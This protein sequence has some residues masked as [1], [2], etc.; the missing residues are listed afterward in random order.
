MPF[1]LC[2]TTTTF[3]QCMHSLFEECFDK[4]FEILKDSISIFGNNFGNCL[5]NLNKVLQRC[6][7]SNYVLNWEKCHF[8]ITEEIAL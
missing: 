7:E 6:E 5:Y 2:N 8:M 3:Q 1:G 4:I